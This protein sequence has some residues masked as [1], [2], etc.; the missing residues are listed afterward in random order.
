[1]NLKR[2][3]TILKY[4]LQTVFLSALIFSL[5]AFSNAKDTI[6]IANYGLKPN[7]NINALPY[8]N[9]AI[10]DSRKHKNAVIYFPVGSYSFWPIDGYSKVYYETNTTDINPKNLAILIERMSNVVVD[11][12]GSQFIMHGLIQ[13]ITVDSSNNVTLKNFTIDWD[14]PLTAQ[15]LVISTTNNYID[16]KINKYENPFTVESEKLFFYDKTWKSQLKS[17]MEIDPE[18]GIFQNGD[19]A[20]GSEWKD[21]KASLSSDSTVRLIREVGFNRLPKVGNYLIL[22]HSERQ[23]SGIYLNASENLKLQN[24]VINY[25]IGIGVLSQYSK[26]IN[27]ENVKTIPN[28]SKNRFYS[29]HADGFHFMGSEGNIRINNC[30][31]KGLMDDPINVHG[32]NIKVIERISDNKLKCRFMEIQSQGLNWAQIGEKVAIIDNKT[33]ISKAYNYVKKFRL[34]SASECEVEFRNSLPEWVQSGL[35]LDNVSKN[36]NLTITNSDFNSCRARGLLVTT[37]GKVLIE[38]NTFESSG[39]AILISGDANYWFE[40]GAVKDVTIRNNIFKP[41]CLTSMYQFT[42]GIISIYPIIP[43]PLREVQ[44]HRNIKIENNYFMPFDYPLL[45][46]KSVSSL[47]FSNNKITRSYDFSAFHDRKFT[48]TFEACKNVKVLS[49]TYSKDVLGKN[50]LL[51]NMNISDLITNDKLNIELK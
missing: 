46:A 2:K 13:P 22:R 44:Y 47:S 14:I 10:T 24:I 37:A 18:T 38:H 25:A 27:I 19:D 50:I 36:A 12:C 9:K 5:S 21:Y 51:Q 41:S 45:Y 11:G 48:L 23:L 16:L 33:M 35:V 31:W 43:N 28:S 4:F 30:V 6:N 8:V 7:Q 42:E 29:C 26:N 40:S 3:N 20:L 1:M 39:S 32:V 15:G 34:I 17:V 49:N